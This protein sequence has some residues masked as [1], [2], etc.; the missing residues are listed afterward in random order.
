MGKR[1]R[2]H[3]RKI[4]RERKQ[5][6]SIQ[7]SGLQQAQF[8]R[9][10]REQLQSGVGPQDSHRM[11]LE[12]QRQ[13][14]EALLPRPRH[15]LGEHSRVRA[16]HAVKVSD[17]QYRRPESGGHF[18]EFMENLH[19]FVWC[20]VV[21]CGRP[22]PQWL[23]TRKISRISHSPRG[24]GRPRHTESK[25]QTPA[26]CRR[27]KVGRLLAAMHWSPRAANRGKYG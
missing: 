21:W 14:L 2:R 10:R 18:F 4:A 23:K 5:Q 26:S 12:S 7:A 3:E 22:R 25:S 1:L 9:S 17:A 24:R 15:N 8:L 6:N 11:R 20:S 19:L 27:T 13:R 16:M